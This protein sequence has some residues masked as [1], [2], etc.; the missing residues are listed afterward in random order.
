MVLL[1]R[2]NT[3]RY[4]GYIIHFG[5]VVMFI[6]MAGGAFNQSREMEMGYGDSLPS[7]AT[8]WSARASPRTPTPST[9]QISPCWTSIRRQR[10]ITQLTP[11][12]RIY[13]AGTDHAQSSTVVAIHSTPR[14]TSTSSSRARTPTPAAPSSRSSSIR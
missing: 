4:G 3:R 14:P 13:F 11:E 10:K 2:R 8:G 9:T 5:I 6:G 1:T 7:A 12:K